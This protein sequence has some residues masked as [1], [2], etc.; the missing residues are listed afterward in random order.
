MKVGIETWTENVPFDHHEGAPHV[1]QSG[2]RP[3]EG[4]FNHTTILLFCL[5]KVVCTLQD[6]KLLFKPSKCFKVVFVVVLF[7]FTVNGIFTFLTKANKNH[8]KLNFTFPGAEISCF[9]LFLL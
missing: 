1:S 6:S 8:C 3:T 7:C 2:L 9:F 4:D 5:S